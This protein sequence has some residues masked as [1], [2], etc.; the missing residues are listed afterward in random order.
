MKSGQFFEQHT[1]SQNVL[2]ALEQGVFVHPLNPPPP[3]PI[4]QFSP[5]PSH[6]KQR[7]KLPMERG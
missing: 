5:D 4:P 7:Q 6:P 1:C 2:L 3:P